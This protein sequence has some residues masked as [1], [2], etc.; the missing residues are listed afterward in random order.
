MSHVHVSLEG[1]AAKRDAITD[2]TL[3]AEDANHKVVVTQK[4]AP[5]ATQA[6]MDLSAGQYRIYALFTS[7]PHRY[8]TERDVTLV[9]ASTV[10]RL[11]LDR[12]AAE[13]ALEPQG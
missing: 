7:V 10:V 1:W 4:L 2:L 8:A 3:S 12:A 13:I 6:S 11:D 5:N 9:P